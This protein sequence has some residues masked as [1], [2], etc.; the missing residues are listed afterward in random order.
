MH[1]SLNL[2][3]KL[4]LSLHNLAHPSLLQTYNHERQS[5]AQDLLS[6]DFE[7][8]NAYS[9]G[10]PQALAAN[11]AQNVRF[12]SGLVEYDENVLNVGG[13]A[14]RGRQRG[15]VLKPGT[16]LPPA[17]ATRYIDAN[18]VDLQLD[19]PLLGQFRIFFFTP[20][21]RLANGMLR[22]IFRK[23]TDP[24]TFLGRISAAAN[25]ERLTDGIPLPESEADEY[26][27]PTRYTSVSRLFTYAVVTSTAKKDFEFGDLP[28]SL[29]E[30]RWI[31]YLDDLIDKNGESCTQK[32]VGDLVENEVVVVNVRPDGYVGC[33]RRFQVD[34]EGSGEKVV[35][36]LEEYYGGILR[37]GE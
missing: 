1:D 20:D 14:R 37:I 7:H 16:L 2:S 18:P 27:Q 29:Q 10:D 21:V 34:G 5:V 31:I 30:S 17:R 23:L 4:S 11:F 26:T 12:I 6:F 35:R 22:G 33:L 8:A 19:I 25:V 3:W 28:A 36:W 13:V 24:T 15:G 9:A 32:W